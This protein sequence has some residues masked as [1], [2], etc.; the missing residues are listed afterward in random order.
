[1]IIPFEIVTDYVA[2][3]DEKYPGPPKSFVR[4]AFS[5]VFFL[6]SEFTRWFEETFGSLGDTTVDEE[7]FSRTHRRSAVIEA[8]TA[9]WGEHGPGPGVSANSRDTKN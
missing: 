2:P 9:L 6:R 3:D 5:P 1:M 7:I 8:I 4:G